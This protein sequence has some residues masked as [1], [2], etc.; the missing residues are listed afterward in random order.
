[1]FEGGHVKSTGDEVD[2]GGRIPDV[3]LEVLDAL[4]PE[5][6]QSTDKNELDSAPDSGPEP[7]VE[8]PGSP[9]P[10]QAPVVTK[11]VELGRGV[12]VKFRGRVVVVVIVGGVT[13]IVH[14]FFRVNLCKWLS[15]G[16]K[17]NHFTRHTGKKK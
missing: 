7:P 10:H 2:H 16:H 6:K 11:V 5:C 17:N 13:I 15:L 4:D 14:L 12:V 1:M 3:E 8:P 9:A